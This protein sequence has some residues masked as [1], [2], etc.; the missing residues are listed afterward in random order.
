MSEGPKAAVK[1]VPQNK[2]QQF[3]KRV[4][5][6]S[7]Q[8]PNDIYITNKTDFKVIGRVFCEFSFVK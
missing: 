4:P 7:F 8:R 6:K 5:T 1:R 2:N 3:K